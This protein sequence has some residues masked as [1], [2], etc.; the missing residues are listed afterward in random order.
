MALTHLQGFSREEGAGIELLLKPRAEGCKQRLIAQ[1]PSGFE[2]GG[3][4]CDVA[5]SF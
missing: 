2:H 5:S 1:N 3:L 4:H